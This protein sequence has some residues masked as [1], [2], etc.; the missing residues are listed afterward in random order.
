MEQ[1]ELNKEEEEKYFPLPSKSP[2]LKN[3]EGTREM[4]ELYPFL[5]SGGTN[6]ERYYF[7][8]IN[9][10]TKYKFNIRPEY[11]SDESNY[12]E[13]FPKRINE[14]LKTNND[15][16]I[17]CVFDWDTIYGD[18]AKLKKHNCFKK[19]FKKEVSNGTVIICPSMPSIEYWFLLHFKNNTSLLKNY[20]EVSQLL[21]PYLR[22]C[23]PNSSP[24][25]LKKL[26]KS[27]KYVSNPQWV[28]NLCAEGRLEKAIQRAEENILKAE[29]END[30][31]NQSYS[32][33]YKIFQ[34]DKHNETLKWIKWIKW[35][36]QFLALASCFFIMM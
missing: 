2:K 4:G 1:R 32:Y 17:F 33:V 30:L 26:L 28:R 5:I 7:T 36:L 16:K 11:F 18:D 13:A 34:T 27:E 31:E 15:V 23:F 9:D 8:H 12:T 21:A 25:K 3:D 20:G 35:I 29:K 14:V 22:P 6:T 10:T 19:Q 24:N